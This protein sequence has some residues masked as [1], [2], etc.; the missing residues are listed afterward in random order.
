MEVLDERKPDVLSKVRNSGIVKKIKGIK[1][2]RIIAAI[3]I[4]AVALLI[5]S[6]VATGNAAR[7]ASSDEQSTEMDE[8][9][10]RLASIL[11]GLEGV[12]RVETMITREDDTIVG[13][14]VIAEGAEDIAVRL[15]LLSAVTT[16]MGVD[17]QIVNVYTMK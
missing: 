2:I 17:K 6:S 9:E 10:S 4:I 12:G 14:L 8:D 1:N 15:R 13:I 16:A 5:Y 11:E 7:T 3:F